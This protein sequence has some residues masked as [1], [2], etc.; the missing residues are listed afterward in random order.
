MLGTTTITITPQ[1]G[2]YTAGRYVA[3]GGTPYT[4]TAQVEDVDPRTAEQLP[5]GARE[6]CKKVARIAGT[7]VAVKPADVNTGYPGDRV[8]Y[9]SD[10]YVVLAVRDYRDHSAGLPHVEAFMA[11][12]GD[13]E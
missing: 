10:S 8:S 12:V 11:L 13:D 4:A 7:T 3:T 1:T 9:R 6:K 5:E 2:T